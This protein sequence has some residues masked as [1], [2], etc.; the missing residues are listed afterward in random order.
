MLIKT[1][2]GLVNLSK[3]DAIII[4]YVS[5]RYI[6]RA[7]FGE[8]YIDIASYAKEEEALSDLLVIE[9][10]LAEENKILYL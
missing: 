2:K 5:I 7:I 6:I 10:E 4:E 8:R 9:S 1:R 3:A